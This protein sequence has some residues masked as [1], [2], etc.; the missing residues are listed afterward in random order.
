MIY[1]IAANARM[2]PKIAK[3]VVISVSK[4]MF[5]QANHGG[6]F[7]GPSGPGAER[8]VTRRRL[9]RG[10]APNQARANVHRPPIG[11]A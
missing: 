7:K 4:E 3:K 8:E 11:L 5:G 10:S 1:A 2:P 6:R 9:T